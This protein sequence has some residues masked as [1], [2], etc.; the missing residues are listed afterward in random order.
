GAGGSIRGGAGRMAAAVCGGAVRLGTG[1]R[2]A[3]RIGRR[4]GR[5]VPRRPHL[6]GDRLL[7]GSA[8]AMSMLRTWLIAT[9]IFVAG[10]AVWAF[11][12]V[13]VFFA[14][15]AA[16]VGLLSAIMIWFARALG[17]W[18]DRRAGR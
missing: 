3:P 14:L 7:V 17:A 15:L 11:A 2:R 1:D 16:A 10:L 6:G 18:R 13:L 9:A 8:P 4:G 12:P 5:P